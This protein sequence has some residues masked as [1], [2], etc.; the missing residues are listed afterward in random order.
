MKRRTLMSLMAGLSMSALLTA[1]ALAADIT[2]GMSWA[3]YQ[4][5]RWKIDESGLRAGLEEMGATLVTADAQSS[6][7]R[8][9]SDIDGLLARGV[10]ALLI[11]AWDSEAVIPSVE[12][13][14]AEGIPVIAYERQIE[15]PGVFYVAFDPVEVGRIQAR[16]LVKVQPKGDYVIIKG[17][18]TDQYAH[19]VLTGQKEIIDPLIDNGDIKIV[20]EQ[21]TD[22]WVPD[23]AQKN[24]EN[25]LT[26]VNDKVDAVLASND[27]TAGG[28][29]A[30]LSSVGLEG[31]P[32]SGQDGDI[33][34]LNRI[35]LGSQ[36]VTAWK[37]AR[38]LG[39]LG[40]KVA[41]ALASGTAPEEIEGAVVWDKGPKGT[42]QNAAVLAPVTITRDNL[43][44][45]LDADWISKEDLCAGVTDNAPDACK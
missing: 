35:A 11:V 21:W 23:N 29:V 22:G 26:A 2:V 6:N 5:E 31:I 36:T 33:A 41:A 20:G 17:S 12:R 40:A 43:D 3:N 39:R 25:I 45:V 34:A 27:G 42:A 37:D 15:Y 7:E 38:E 18:P 28:V 1:P 13:A 10:D 9:A 16:E 32:V 30:A 19:Y 8:Q 14:L 4:E 24:M 44:V